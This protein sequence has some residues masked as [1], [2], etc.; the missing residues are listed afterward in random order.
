PGPGEVTIS[1]RAA[2]VNFIDIYYRTGLY[3]HPLPHGLGFEGAGVIEAVGDGV[4]G[5]TV[6]DRVAHAMG[7][8]GSYAER[9]TMPVSTLVRLPD[10]ISFEQG[11][12][13]MM[14]GLTA[15]YLLRQTY[16]VKPGE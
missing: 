4:Q 5:F 11:A 10:D 6:G 7:P 15:Q 1:C 12:A 2:G 9:R 3:P 16:R 14:K 13:V 8:L